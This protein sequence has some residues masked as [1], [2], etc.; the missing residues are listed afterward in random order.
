LTQAYYNDGVHTRQFIY[1]NNADI[2]ANVGPAGNYADPSTWLSKKYEGSALPAGSA[3]AI[4]IDPAFK[5]PSTLR[6]NISY[7]RFFSDKFR[8]TILGVYNVGFNDNYW[9]NANRT[10][11]GTNPVDGREIT[12]AKVP[13]LNNVIVFTNADWTSKYLAAQL[14]LT[15]KIGKDGLLNLTL[16]KAKGMGVTV[17]HAGGVFD[18]AEY[19]GADYYNRYK[20]HMSNSNQNGVGDKAVLVFASPQMRGWSIG[21]S[22]MAAKQRRFSILAG[23]NPNGS[24]DRDLAYIPT[25]NELTIA[26]TR[27]LANVA[28]EV[29]NVL[30]ESAGQISGVYQGVY[31]WMY[32]TSAS[33]SKRFKIFDQYGVTLRAD[34]FNL[35]NMIS[36]TA[37]YYNSLN[38]VQDDYYGRYIT[39]YNYVAPV[40]TPTPVAGR[41]T[42]NGGQG[43]YTR[44]G[45]PFSIQLGAKVDF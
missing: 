10:I 14:D 38:S 31:P 1:T 33:I 27:V 26:E 34:C 11:T 18:D 19:V 39:L 28:Q 2:V 23:G 17:Y 42:V 37:G 16:T 44:G 40:T 24:V 5:M 4:M 22:L 43:T 35:L 25:A 8:A 21:F 29:K 9:V 20:T 6:S 12:A 7:T 30:N 3:N 13:A 15:M 36:S 32:Q 41:Y 45:Q